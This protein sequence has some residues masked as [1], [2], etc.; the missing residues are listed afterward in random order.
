MH[1]FSVQ[2]GFQTII[3]GV[4][5]HVQL[6][7]LFSI[8]AHLL[9]AFLPRRL[10]CGLCR[11]LWNLRGILQFQPLFQGVDEAVRCFDLS[12]PSQVGN[13]EL[14]MV[15]LG[16]L[17]RKKSET[18]YLPLLFM[19]HFKQILKCGMASSGALPLSAILTKS[20]GLRR[21]LRPE[22]P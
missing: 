17:R 13:I 19:Q 14:R 10:H 8:A 7:Q 2:R 15:R 4:Q 12:K 16:D 20:S 11:G 6:L 18:S 5:H 21:S 3:L 9:E 1:L 22:G